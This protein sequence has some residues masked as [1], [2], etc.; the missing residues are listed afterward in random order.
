MAISGH[1]EE[2]SGNY[3]LT[4]RHG[5]RSCLDGCGLGTS[6]LTSNLCCGGTKHHRAES[7]H[8]TDYISVVW[9]GSILDS[10]GFCEHKFDSGKETSDVS[11]ATYEV[12][13]VRIFSQ[14]RIGG[15][16]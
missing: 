5:S 10:N 6:G 13:T 4:Y 12:S 7:V 9:R 15:I 8:D 2:G 11:G 16:S 3:M 14:V 1:L